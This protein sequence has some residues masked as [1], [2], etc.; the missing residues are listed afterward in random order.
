MTEKVDKTLRLISAFLIYFLTL[1]GLLKAQT[2]Q[3]MTHWPSTCV[4]KSHNYL[5]FAK[6]M[7]AVVSFGTYYRGKSQI[8]VVIILLHLKK[9]TIIG[10]I[11][12][13][14]TREVAKCFA[15]CKLDQ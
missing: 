5:V 13:S 4:F 15:V 6:F 2:C 7:S 3:R 1:K 11:Y 14:L 8:K 12:T 10:S 9:C